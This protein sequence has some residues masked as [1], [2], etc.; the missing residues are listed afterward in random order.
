MLDFMFLRFNKKFVYKKYSFH[1]TISG[2]RNYF[3]YGRYCNQVK[4]FLKS[5]Y[6]YFDT[7][8]VKTLL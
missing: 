7:N 2:M 6:K 4:I 5:G 1:F 3:H 8:K